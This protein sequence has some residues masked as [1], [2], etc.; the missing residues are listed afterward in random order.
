MA[1]AKKPRKYKFTNLTKG[2]VFIPA[3]RRTLSA[4]KEYPHVWE[5]VLDAGTKRLEEQGLL[6]IEDVGESDV[7]IKPDPL[8]RKAEQE[9]LE[10]KLTKKVRENLTELNKEKGNDDATV[11]VEPVKIDEDLDKPPVPEPLK[12]EPAPKPKKKKSRLDALVDDGSKKKSKK[13]D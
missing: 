8:E 1:E 2:L 13:N 11:K 7:V 4:E 6:K 5:G 3:I 9:E 12:E 10:R